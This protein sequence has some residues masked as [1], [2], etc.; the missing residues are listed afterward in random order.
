[1]TC[2]SLLPPG[3]S[4]YAQLVPFELRKGSEGS[5]EILTVIV[6]QELRGRSEVVVF[7]SDRPVRGI[8]K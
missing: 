2:V 3:G 1:M 4:S 8:L 5:G 7:L 6:P